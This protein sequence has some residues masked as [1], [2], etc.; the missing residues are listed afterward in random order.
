M[1]SRKDKFIETYETKIKDIRKDYYKQMTNISE[2]DYYAL[3]TELF[4]KY[5]PF[6][7]SI[8]TLLILNYKISSITISIVTIIVLSIIIELNELKL[9]I[10]NKNEYLKEIRKHGFL[11]IDDYEYK[12]REYLTCEEG[13]YAKIQEELMLKYNITDK[14]KI[15][16]EINGNRYYVWFD[17]DNNKIQMLNIKLNEK[18]IIES[19]RLSDI[20]YFKYDRKK[21]VTILK[22]E[23]EEKT[24]TKE[25][26]EILNK[27]FDKKL[28]TNLKEYSKEDY[29]YD[30]ERFMH[31]IKKDLD[32]KFDFD[33]EKRTTYITNLII[34]ILFTYG[35]VILSNINYMSNISMFIKIAIIFELFFIN[36]NFKELLNYLSNYKNEKV[37]KEY[38]NSNN[39]VIKRFN[40]LK[41]SLKI[42]EETITIKDKNNKEYI[43]WNNGGYFHI[44]LN[45]PQFN[46]IYISVK[47][48]EIS[49][50]KTNKN[51]TIISFK[52]KEMIFNKEAYYLLKDK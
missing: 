11:T 12:I 42:P 9:G 35:L 25:A 17:K 44:F 8:I 24:Y 36:Y 51:T 41:E 16:E 32:K 29:I 1:S 48:D 21:Q 13:E 46:T 34:L 28:L 22:T 30:Y 10:N 2:T 50:N 52:D 26:Y 37:Y 27:L 49:I 39:E 3:V 5:I 40:D 19:F 18:P 20:T 6:L 31:K 38:I 4:I 43:V 45:E 15:I 23:S 14:T 33:Q 7:V 47:K